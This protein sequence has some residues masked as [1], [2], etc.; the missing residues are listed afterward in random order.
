[1]YGDTPHGEIDDPIA[2][3]SSYPPELL[4]LARRCLSFLES[5]DWKWDLNTLLEQPADLLAA[6]MAVRS[7]GAEIRRQ[8]DDRKNKK[9]P[10]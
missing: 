2:I 4:D 8:D 10:E 9:A 1:M 5:I 3:L 6:V 7:I